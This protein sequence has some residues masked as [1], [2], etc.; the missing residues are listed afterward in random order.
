MQGLYFLQAAAA[1]VNSLSSD[2][3]TLIAASDQEGCSLED[4]ILQPCFSVSLEGN[5]Q[6]F[7]I[8]F[9]CKNS[10][11]QLNRRTCLNRLVPRNVYFQACLLVLGQG[12]SKGSVQ[13]IPY[14]ANWL[15]SCAR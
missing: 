10:G 3:H 1:L 9:G 2:E 11:S 13:N 12:M 15:P 6:A 8:G 5:H 4:K 14:I 7:C